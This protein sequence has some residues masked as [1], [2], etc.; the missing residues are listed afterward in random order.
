MV[1]TI[2]CSL[3]GQATKPRL[4]PHTAP[5]AQPEPTTLP[6]QLVPF[7]WLS[8]AGSVQLPLRVPPTACALG[9]PGPPTQM[10]LYGA[11]LVTGLPAG[12]APQ[13]VPFQRTMVALSPAAQTSL[14]PTPETA[15]SVVA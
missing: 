4:L 15:R 2:L 1:K 8:I 12:G 10:P 5:N 3:A 9:E 7:Q 6:V 13:V 11:V 14:M